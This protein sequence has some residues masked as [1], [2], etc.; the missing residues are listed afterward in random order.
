MTLFSRVLLGVFSLLMPCVVFAHSPIKGLNDFYN[1]VLHPALVPAHLLCLLVL[2]LFLG[3]KDPKEVQLPLQIFLA[4]T[5]IGLLVSNLASGL[6]LELV[7]LIGAA[8]IGL[9]TATSLPLPASVYSITAIYIGLAVGLDSAQETLTGMARVKALLGSGIGIVICLGASLMLAECF[10]NKPW[11][12]IAIR[13]FGSWAAASAILVLSLSFVNSSPAGNVT[14]E[15]RRATHPLW[16][17]RHLET[18][19]SCST[20]K[21]IEL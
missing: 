4:S 6:N 12:R 20:G 1:G 3:Q 21:T 11:Q 13:V 18:A 7:L 15:V 2:G 17:Q 9:M 14:K 5:V 19:V 10:S 16:G 8:I